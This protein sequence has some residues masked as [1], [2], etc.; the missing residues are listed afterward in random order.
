[1]ACQR[2]FD[3][4]RSDKRATRLGPS[5]AR[6]RRIGARPF[7]RIEGPVRAAP[8]PPSRLLSLP[9]FDSVRLVVPYFVFAPL[10]AT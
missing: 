8:E 7:L 5:S 9:R 4:G 3:K 10:T 2:R 1:M 6:A